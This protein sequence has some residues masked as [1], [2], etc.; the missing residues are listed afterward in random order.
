MDAYTEHEGKTCKFLSSQLGGDQSWF[1]FNG[2]IKY[3]SVCPRS[4]YKYLLISMMIHV[5]DLH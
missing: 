4:F 5:L 3:L 1:T 2:S